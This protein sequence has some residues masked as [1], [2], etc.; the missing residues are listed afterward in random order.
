M[1]KRLHLFQILPN[2]SRA[3]TRRYRTSFEPPKA[4]L[5]DDIEPK[6]C[7][8]DKEVFQEKKITCS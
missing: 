3:V 4:L 8:Q 2:L 5:F 7:K 1:I 6:T